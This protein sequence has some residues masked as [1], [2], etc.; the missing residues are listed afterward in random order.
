[1]GET[2]GVN[3]IVGVA[4]SIGVDVA[5]KVGVSL[6]VDEVGVSETTGVDEGVS[7][8][9]GV[10]EVAV[11]EPSGVDDVAVG[12]PS[13]VDEVAVGEAIGVAVSDP[14]GVDVN[15]AVGPL[16]VI[17]RVVPTQSTAVRMLSPFETRA[18]HSI[19]L[20]PATRPV[21]LKVNTTPLVV[22]LLPLLP[23]MAKMKLPA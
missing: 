18:V 11:G 6:G 8:T 14:S 19:G 16:P 1:M 22:A 7:D 3:V 12:E 4:V 15:V 13:G 17:V 23:A 21:T 2:T 10:E 9:T 5:V 20:C